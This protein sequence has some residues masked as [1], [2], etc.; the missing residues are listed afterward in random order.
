MRFQSF[1]GLWL[2][3]VHGLEWNFLVANRGMIEN[4]PRLPVGMWV[5]MGAEPCSAEHLWPQRNGTIFAAGWQGLLPAPCT[6]CD[7]GIPTYGD[8]I[9]ICTS[10]AAWSALASPAAPDQGFHGVLGESGCKFDTPPIDCMSPSRYP[11]CSLPSAAMTTSQYIIKY[12]TRFPG[13]HCLQFAI[14]LPQ[15]GQFIS[16][17]GQHSKVK[18][19]TRHLE[20]W[21]C[22]P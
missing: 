16:S 8:P 20:R 6:S 15:K 21:R 18:H 3:F 10:A 17:K 14:L 1:S 12:T 9:P 7:F 13:C 5:A 4:Q 19:S 11:H 22:A 2:L